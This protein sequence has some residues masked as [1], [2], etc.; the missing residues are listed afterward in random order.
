MQSIGLLST[1]G[2]MPLQ[3]L[4]L[5]FPFK[6]RFVDKNSKNVPRFFNEASEKT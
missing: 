1:A 2:D 3:Q 4:R 6:E 5:D